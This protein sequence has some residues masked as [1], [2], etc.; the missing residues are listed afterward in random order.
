MRL[1]YV[2]VVVDDVRF[3]RCVCVSDNAI[4]KGR[5][6]EDG[7]ETPADIKHRSL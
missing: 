7:G 2:T 6:A 5:H 4:A 3:V 1:M